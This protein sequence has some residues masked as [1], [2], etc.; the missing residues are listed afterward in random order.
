MFKYYSL[1]SVTCLML[2]E[3]DGAKELMPRPF[4]AFVKTASYGRK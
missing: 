2:S 4:W 3:M 1:M